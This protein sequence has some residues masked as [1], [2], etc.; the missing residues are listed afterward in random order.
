[1]DIRRLCG[2]LLLG[3]CAMAACAAPVSFENLARH[4]QYKNVKISPDGQYLAAT[5]V[6][7]GQTV[8][9]LVHLSDM[10]G[11]TLRPRE[12]DDVVDFWWVSPTRVLY[13]V[14]MRWGGYDAPLL[15]GELFG[16]NADGTGADTLYGFRKG[17]PSFASH[18]DRGSAERG[19]ARFIAAIPD[20]P[21]DALVAISDWDA[22]GNEVPLPVVYRMNVHDGRKVKIADVPL[23]GAAFVADH[24]GH[25]RFA[26]G[27]DSVGDFKVYERAAEGG[28]WKPMPEIATHARA[29]PWAFSRDDSVVYFDC[30]AD[31][32]GFGLCRWDVA[33]R[34]MANVWSHPKVEPDWLLW[35]LADDAI[36]GVTF[37]DGRPGLSVFDR[38]TPDVQAL[39]ALMQQFPG[40]SVRFV[41]GTRDGSKTVVLVDAD[42]DPGTFYLLDN[43][44]NKLTP[45]L[46]RAPWIDPERMASKQ[47]IEFA[48]RDGLD[49]HGYLSLPP[50]RENAKHLP[51]VV[52]VHGGPYGVRDDWDY[53]SDVQALATHGYAVLQV[54]FRGSGG[55]GYG[56]ER[57]GWREWGGKMQDDVTDATR[58]AIAQGYADPGRIC[59]MGASYG[60]Y[61]ALEGAVKESDLYRCAI[62]YVGVYDLRLM[63]TRGDIP[64]ST[65]GENYLKRVLGTDMDDLARR[66]PLYNLDRLKARVMLVVGGRD[67]RVP[68]VQGQSLHAKLQER[69]IAHE[70]LYKPNES[71]GFYDEANVAELY[72]KVV[73]F[74]D[75]NIGSASAATQ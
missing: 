40:E 2:A 73:Q 17:G 9:A 6:I 20:D 46:A 12:E 42:A 16:I 65:Y 10:K 5:A 32:G 74:L 58:W 22:A 29:H 54:N 53:D 45:L 7:K 47:P 70:W 37:I 24:H 62:G 69:G 59:I 30:P 26:Y 1:M 18:I 34:T 55:Y 56:F 38:S 28:D 15:T 39:V 35:G 60:G 36:I 71:H 19:S 48:A 57:A 49:L 21:D 43:K 4:A 63:Y 3:L 66:S 25:V 50:G 31:A 52:L 68:P 8:L 51:M 27:E 67:Q 61:A 23:R 13:T 33:K 75:S 11:T 64:Q 41:S 44:A 72:A 14:G